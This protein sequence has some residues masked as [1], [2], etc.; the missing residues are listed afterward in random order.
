[1][2]S[3]YAR[4]LADAVV[5]GRRLVIR[6]QVRR[7]FCDTADCPAVTFAEQVPGLTVRYA[8]RSHPARQVLERLGL[9]SAAT[10]CCGW[11]AGCQTHRN[12]R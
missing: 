6:L 3:R 12:G 8:R 2:R 10:P 9:A 11:S 4:R 5:A 7:F 1:M